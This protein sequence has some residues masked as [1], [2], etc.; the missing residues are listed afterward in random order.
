MWTTRVGGHDGH[1]QLIS[2]GERFKLAF[3]ERDKTDNDKSPRNLKKTGLKTLTFHP[4]ISKQK[5]RCSIDIV[6]YIL[7]LVSSCL[8]I[9]KKLLY[10]IG[11]DRNIISLLFQWKESG[12]NWFILKDS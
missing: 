7:L 1:E 9:F 5:R 4:L 10:S 8:K 3:A 11:D 6:K 12:K 2:N